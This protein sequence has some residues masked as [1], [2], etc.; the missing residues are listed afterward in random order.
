MCSVILLQNQEGRAGFAFSTMEQPCAA[1][2]ARFVAPIALKTLSCY[3]PAIRCGFLWPAAWMWIPVQVQLVLGCLQ[4]SH[5]VLAGGWPCWSP[6]R[7]S[8]SGNEVCTGVGGIE[9]A[10]QYN[11][12]GYLLFYFYLTWMSL[13]L[14]NELSHCWVSVFFFQ[15]MVQTNVLFKTQR[16]VI[17]LPKES[18]DGQDGR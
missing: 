5:P 11:I 16:S 14:D 8:A 15:D 18:E 4:V 10:P 2:K 13:S 17:R 7:S 3:R 12:Q 6:S 9:R 1:R